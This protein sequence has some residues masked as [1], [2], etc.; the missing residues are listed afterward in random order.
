MIETIVSD[1]GNV[2]LR[3]DNSVF[4]RAI[5]RFSDRPAGEI[6]AIAGRNLDLLI[7]FEKGAV[8]PIDFYRNAK[9]LL[10]ISAGYEEFF[11]AYCKGVFTLAPA[12]LDLYRRLK[13]RHRMV[14]LSNTD[15]IRWSHVKAKF[16]EILLFDEYVLSFDVGA[17]K[18]QPEIYYEALRAG[19]A[20][21]GRTVF[22]DDLPANVDAAARLGMKGIL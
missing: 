8:S 4:Y 7:L 20:A 19:G 6:A 14:L 12:V 21:P 3:F 2:L 5:S 11:A 22:I 17:A 10:E 15:I 16:P 1:L 13:A 18:P 9:D